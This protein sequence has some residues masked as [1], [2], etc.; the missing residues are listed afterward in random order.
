MAAL[1]PVGRSAGNPSSGR[2]APDVFPLTKTGTPHPRARNRVRPGHTEEHTITEQ[3]EDTT[4]DEPHARREDFG[5]P[6]LDEEPPADSTQRLR[7]AVEA[8]VGSAAEG[9]NS[10]TPLKN[11]VE[12]FPAMLDAIR[13]AAHTIDFVTFVYW[14]GRV[15]EEFAT[16][17]AER[18]LAGV[19]VRVILDAFGSRP[20]RP[21]LIQRMT[22]AGV[23]V[24]RF[25]PVVRWKFWETDHRTHRKILIVDNQI[26]F[27]GG[28]GIAAEWEGDARNPEEWRDTH[29]RIEGPAALRLKASF[30]T[31]WRD[32]G[33]AIDP[34]DVDVE[35][36][37]EAGGI[38]AAVIDGSAQI[39]FDDAELALEALVAGAQQRIVI[40]TPYLNPTVAMQELMIEA[41]ERGVDVDIMIPGPHIDKRISGV[42]AEEMYVPLVESGA[43]V[44]I[45]QPT[46]MHVKAMLVDGSVALI[47]SIN[48]NRRSV[49]KDEEVA[50]AIFDRQLTRTLEHHFR[51]DLDKCIPAEPD[52]A[53]TPLRRRLA[54]KLLRPIKSEI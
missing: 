36:P 25:R 33:H 44:W 53:D 18:S 40:Q 31:D 46:M 10:I 17:L 32:T 13:N 43:R 50:V 51:E 7:R 30:L 54:A 47:G 26:A 28:V 15:A 42:M 24:E 12:I 2:A 48:V 5:L 39:G 6:H 41:L 3:Q 29:F 8:S 27:T 37:P 52:V 23:M 9:G 1:I 22:A 19:R 4:N 11:G 14:T 20:M 45:Y 21:E 34:T 16:A 49:E 38:D 35:P